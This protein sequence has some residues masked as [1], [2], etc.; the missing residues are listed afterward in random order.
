MGARSPRPRRRGADC[1]LSDRPESGLNLVGRV[2]FNWRKIA[3]IPTVLRLLATYL[4]LSAQAGQHIP[5]ASAAR[6]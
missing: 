6:V 2:H 4:R 3:A 5:L 1:R